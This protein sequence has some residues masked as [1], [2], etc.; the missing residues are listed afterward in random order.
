MNSPVLLCGIVSYGFGPNGLR[1]PGIAI[2]ISVFADAVFVV[3]AERILSNRE[4]G[5][6]SWFGDIVEPAVPESTR[7]ALEEKLLLICTENCPGICIAYSP[8]SSAPSD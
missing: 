1:S 8:G 4:A 5:V 3:E 6:I 2:Q 7:R